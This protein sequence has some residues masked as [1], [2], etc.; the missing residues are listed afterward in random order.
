MDET[1]AQLENLTSVWKEVNAT[2]AELRAAKNETNTLSK[3]VKHVIVHYF[4]ANA[5]TLQSA[6]TDF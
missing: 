1:K 3:K 2:K 4:L 5:S 6:I